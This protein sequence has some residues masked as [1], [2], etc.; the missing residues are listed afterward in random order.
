MCTNIS[1]N[2]D[3]CKM[4]VPSISIALLHLKMVCIHHTVLVP[5]PV[6]HPKALKHRESAPLKIIP[7]TSNQ[8]Q[9]T[10]KSWD[11][12]R[13]PVTLYVSLAFRLLFSNTRQLRNLLLKNTLNMKIAIFSHSD[14]TRK[15]RIKTQFITRDPW[16]PACCSLT[17]KGSWS[18]FTPQAHAHL[19]WLHRGEHTAEW[20][21]VKAVALRRTLF[22]WSNPATT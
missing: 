14:C 18:L 19:L 15:W 17:V 13:L 10:Q 12:L 22:T 4:R 2:Q 11:L 9:Y 6:F 8:T 1:D 5:G 21:H 16:R 20:H 3:D 7:V